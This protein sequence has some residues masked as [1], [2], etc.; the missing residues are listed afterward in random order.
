V[1]H[2]NNSL[3]NVPLDKIQDYEESVV[4]YVHASLNDLLEDMKASKKISDETNAKLLE[5]LKSYTE[6]Y[7]D[8]L[9][10]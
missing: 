5:A 3:K 4:S 2:S 1:V 8:S 6:T 10:A 7:I 9:K